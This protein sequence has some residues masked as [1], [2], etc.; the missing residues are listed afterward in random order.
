MFN[1]G[2]AGVR[3]DRL[4]EYVAERGGDLAGRL[5]LNAGQLEYVCRCLLDDMRVRGAV[6]RELLRYHPDHPTYPDHCRAARWERRIARPQGFPCDSTGKPVSHLDPDEIPKGLKLHNAWRKTGAGG[7]G[8]R[9]ER[10]LKSLMA[11]FGG[12]APDEHVMVDCLTFLKAGSF[13]VP[14]DLFGFTKR[15]Q[16]LQV[17]AESIR[18]VLLD[19]QDRRRCGVC[20]AA[21]PFTSVGFPCPLCHGQITT[22]PDA[23]VLKHR[24]V[25]RIRAERTV[26]LVAGEHTAQ[27][28][29]ATRLEL[30]EQFKAPPA[31]SKVNILA[32]SPTLEMGIDVGGLDA[33]ALRN[34]PPRPDNYAQR[35]GRAGRRTRVGLVL[36]YARSTPHD[37]YLYDKPAEM[38]AGE[39]PAPALALGNRDVL[40]RHVSAIVFSNAE[41]GLDGRMVK[42]VSPTGEINNE[43]V[44]ALITGLV[45]QFEPSLALAQTAFGDEILSASTLDG[46]A[47]R[48]HLETIPDRVRDVINRTARQVLE[49][50]QALD[51]YTAQ[52][53]GK[54]AATK[55]GDLVA[56]LLGIA[57]ERQAGVDAD[58][59]SAG[60][61]L[62]RFAEFGI[63]PGYE[64][65]TEPASLRLLGDKNEEEP[66]TV[67]RRFGIAQF[68]PNASVFARTGRWRVMGLDTASPWNPRGDAA[69]WS[70]RLCRSCGLRFGSDHPKCPR[71][72][73][74]Q[75]GPCLPAAE[76]GGFVARRDE[77]PVLDEEE[78]FAERNLVRAHPQWDG[79]VVGRWDTPGAWALRLS[80]GEEVR[81][82]NE[83]P[84][85]PEGKAEPNA[86]HASARGY[87]LCGSCGRTL[88]IPEPTGKGKG[89]PKP[90]GKTPQSTDQFGHR[91]DC[92]KAGVTPK[93]LAI[94]TSTKAEVLRLIAPVPASLSSDDVK[95]WALSL[96]Y[97]LRT[98]IRQLYML[99]GPE[100]EFEFE[101][102]WPTGEDEQ[103][104][105]IVSLSFIDGSLGGTGYLTRVAGEM[106]LVARRA[107]EHLDHPGCDTACYRC[108]KSYANQRFHEYL[109]WPLAA[110]ALEAL[111]S[112]PTLARP[113]QTGDLNDPGPWLEAYAAGV[114]SPLELKFLR[115]FEKH[116][117]HPQKQVE[118]GPGDGRPISVADFA[119]PVARLAIYIDGAAFH[120]GA[121]LRRDRFIRDR[122]RNGT[123]PW[124]VEE[125]RA[126]DLAGGENLVRRLLEDLNRK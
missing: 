100:I 78:R 12:A 71:C 75:P 27:V 64:F 23:E 58:D 56:R 60:Y 38:I 126:V 7:N 68:Q 93:A 120:V 21:R 114:G 107:L 121:N 69:A 110:P 5:W 88:S 103:R 117:F 29:N 109:R 34:V 62:R 45:A 113:L 39:V 80:R 97:A 59:R 98:G 106:H 18:L 86:L 87:F 22:W 73:G 91:A 89:T 35:G 32:C 55:A 9:L 51:S 74:D 15:H 19:E 123:P 90:K 37:Q 33:V 118:V 119:V 13:V 49:L 17:N 30:E 24:S 111:A 105:G 25:R 50:R 122:L 66:I 101:G 61:P 41:P 95:P 16:L 26:S 72:G 102:P 53:L 1:L 52:L 115:L 84:T 79:D 44:E 82:L 3:Y 85:I 63:L 112:E 54:Q 14:S 70:Y 31:T 76:F 108:L 2:V 124:R 20:G 96:G 40:L 11:S 46:Q 77:S 92:P 28:P 94:A 8:P 10:V 4:G 116:G 104:I 36:G 57:T 42:Y 99:D 125:L 83:G 6:S 43:A 48:T 65:P 47:L 81:W 67:A